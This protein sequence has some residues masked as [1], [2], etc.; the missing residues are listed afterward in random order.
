MFGEKYFDCGERTTPIGL[1]LGTL[2]IQNGRGAEEHACTNN[3]ASELLKADLQPPFLEHEE[4]SC[5]PEA[6]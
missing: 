1:E 5:V 3:T 4:Y 2:K 6:I